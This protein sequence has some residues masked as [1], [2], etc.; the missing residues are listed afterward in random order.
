MTIAFSIN[1]FILTSL[2][3]YGRGSKGAAM[4]ADVADVARP[5]RAGERR[6]GTVSEHDMRLVLRLAKRVGAPEVR[7]GRMT[8]VLVRDVAEA[9]TNLLLRLRRPGARRQRLLRLSSLR[10]PRALR[11]RALY[12]YPHQ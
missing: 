4:A 12:T 10:D 2:E 8:M 5:A 3:Y 1:Q 7:V 9:L 11:T 6:G